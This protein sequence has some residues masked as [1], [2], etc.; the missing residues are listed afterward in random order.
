VVGNEGRHSAR[1]GD[2]SLNAK[3]N[4]RCRAHSRTVPLAAEVSGLNRVSWAG[5]AEW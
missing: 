4:F 3:A 2:D 5:S 1:G